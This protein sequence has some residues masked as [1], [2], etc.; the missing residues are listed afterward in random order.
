MQALFEKHN[1][2]QAPFEW[3]YDGLS[4]VML[5]DVLSSHKGLCIV[6]SMLCII[7]AAPLGIDLAMMRVPQ[8]ASEASLAGVTSAL[9][10]GGR[11]SPASCMVYIHMES[12]ASA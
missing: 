2:R 7:V 5:P 10:Y 4:P 9:E 12:C 3:V 1:F 8:P 11:R 6:L